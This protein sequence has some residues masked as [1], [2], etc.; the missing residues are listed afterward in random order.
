[1]CHIEN[2]G[3]IGCYSGLQGTGIAPQAARLPGCFSS[4]SSMA[5]PK[6]PLCHHSSSFKPSDDDEA[7]TDGGPL[8]PPQDQTD[9]RDASS[10]R[11]VSQSSVSNTRPCP[12]DQYST[13]CTEY[14]TT[15]AMASLLGGR[16][17]HRDR[18]RG[19]KS[20]LRM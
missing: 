7:G 4:S 1:M 13:S 17:G 3:M 16:F 18:G 20:R 11:N 9:H 5:P 15:Q 12:L 2:E 8:V 10:G 6:A 14:V 19:T